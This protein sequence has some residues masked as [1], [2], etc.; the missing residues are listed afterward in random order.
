MLLD[1]F[2]G[3]DIQVSSG[4]SDCQSCCQVM[5]AQV[6][7]LSDTELQK[8]YAWID[9]IPLSRYENISLVYYCLPYTNTLGDNDD[10]SL[11]YVSSPTRQIVYVYNIF[12]YC[13]V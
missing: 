4:R 10:H 6:G 12:I 13:N 9:T 7:S 2:Y 8:L 5:S 11:P 1:N 3:A